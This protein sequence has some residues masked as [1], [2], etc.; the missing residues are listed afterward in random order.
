MT[1]WRRRFVLSVCV[2]LMRLSQHS[3][4]SIAWMQAGAALASRV[5]VIVLAEMTVTLRC[6]NREPTPADQLIDFVRNRPVIEELIYSK[7]AGRLRQIAISDMAVKEPHIKLDIP[8]NQIFLVR[9]SPDGF[10]HRQLRTLADANK[11]STLQAQ[12]YLGKAGITNWLATTPFVQIMIGDNPGETNEVTRFLVLAKNSI[13]TVLNLGV[14]PLDPGS[15]VI[16]ENKLQARKLGLLLSGSLEISPGGFLRALQYAAANE[17]EQLRTEL[18][19]TRNKD[20]PAFFPTR[21]TR[22]RVIPGGERVLVDDVTIAK[23]RISG[24]RLSAE[25]LL[26]D[27]LLHPT[28]NNYRST[29]LMTN[30]TQFRVTGGKLIPVPSRLRRPQ[31]SYLIRGAYAFIVLASVILPVIWLSKNRTKQTII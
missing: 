6:M 16:A 13:D 5:A 28:T 7:P 24:T 17:P 23:L 9:W 29:S 26:P 10:L 4:I 25:M 19:Y 3:I 21:I 31:S 30:N 14:A 15:L 22:Y 20:V 18:S 11:P 1:K 12:Y 8:E 27:R 2:V